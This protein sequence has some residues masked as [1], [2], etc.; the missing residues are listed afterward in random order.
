MRIGII[1]GSTRQGRAG[2]K[3]GRWVFEAAQQRAT[4]DIEY[5]L[6]DLKDFN[7]PL[8][9]AP[10]LPAMA[11]KSYD[12]EQVTQW[13]YVIDACDAYIFVTPEY[14]HSVP[15]GLKNAVDHLGAEWRDKA[16]AFVGYSG[17]GAVRSVE[18]WRQIMANFNMFDVRTQLAINVFS[19]VIDGVYTPNERAAAELDALFA[20]LESV[21]AKLG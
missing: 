20:E 10:V 19:D 12:S 7:L 3:I 14:N 2:D 1:I 9:D 4:A 13:S 15:A 21:T 11:G 18:H 17:T 8:F 6:I 5:E 16:I